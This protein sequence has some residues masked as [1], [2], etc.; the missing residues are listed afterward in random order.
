MLVCENRECLGAADAERKSRLT[1][2][3]ARMRWKF[4]FLCCDDIWIILMTSARG[5]NRERAERFFLVYIFMRENEYHR[6]YHTKKEYKF[7]S[8]REK[9]K[10]GPLGHESRELSSRAYIQTF[11]C[12]LV[13]V[14]RV[15]SHSDIIVI[16]WKL[17]FSQS[18]LCVGKIFYI[19]THS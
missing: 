9:E 6:I 16:S 19:P 18:H 15:L 14:S 13:V 17:N 1:K 3:N 4:V 10:R 7:W 2:K 11:L 8:V 12:M 5:R